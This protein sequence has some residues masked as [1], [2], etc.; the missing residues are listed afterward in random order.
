M[1]ASWNPETMTYTLRRGGSHRGLSYW[2]DGRGDERIL[3]VTTGYR[4][5]ELN[6]KTGQPIAGFGTNGIVDLKVG[7]VIGKDQCR[8][9]A[10][11]PRRP[12]PLAEP[13]GR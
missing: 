10:D 2:T 8:V 9:L 7:V 11:A 6:A 3:Y 4:L 12:L 13:R 1:S 5:I